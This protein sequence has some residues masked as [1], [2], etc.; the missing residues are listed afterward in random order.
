MADVAGGVAPGADGHALAVD[1]GLGA[2]GG[3]LA[4]GLAAVGGVDVELVVLVADEAPRGVD[5]LEGEAAGVA[6][7]GADGP[8]GVAGRGGDLLG[9]DGLAVVGEEPA[10]AAGRGGGEGHRGAD[11]QGVADVEVRLGVAG[12][13]DVGLHLGVGVVRGVAG[14][15]GALVKGA[16]G[17][18]AVVAADAEDDGALLAHGVVVA[19][20]GARAVVDGLDGVR[21]AVA[22]LEG[23]VVAR[24][25]LEVA[26]DE[27]RRLHRVVRLLA[28]LA[29]G[30]EVV[31]Q[32]G[33]DP[34]PV[35]VA[36]AAPAVALAEVERLHAP[37]A[38]AL[39]GGVDVVR[40]GVAVVEAARRVVVRAVE[41]GVHALGVV[42]ERDALGLV[43]AVPR[44][45][46]AEHAV[47]P[48]AVERHGRAVRAR[49]EVEA[50]GLGTVA[51]AAAGGTRQV[52]LVAGLVVDDGDAARLAVAEGVLVVDV[53][54]AARRRRRDVL[55]R[56]VAAE[57]L[58]QRAAIAAVEGAGQAVGGDAGRPAG[59]V[60]V[61]GALAAVPGHDG[62]GQGLAVGQ[63]AHGG[64]TQGQS[65]SVTAENHLVLVSVCE[66]R[67]PPIFFLE[68]AT[69]EFCSRQW[70]EKNGKVRLVRGRMMILID[71][72][73]H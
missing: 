71:H 62:R 60:D 32:V 36:G 16:L 25:A 54:H 37:V 6:E 27:A 4:E 73:G 8:L 12:G 17:A 5:G 48:L 10:R 1:A 22:A 56:P 26:G 42:V 7:A 2:V 51:G 18:V 52:V 33:H 68:K 53:G 39:A 44:H 11:G 29:A 24:V 23:P 30:E 34:G 13:G 46:R 50:A 21:V 49:Q 65:P 47:R 55:R 35:A 57:E 63:G 40:L 64:N 19:L 31:L 28:L 70:L 41:H 15:H 20:G 9:V 67:I 3:V 69:L 58:V 38:D 66:T 59:L 43:V 14:D 72:D 61:A 45:G